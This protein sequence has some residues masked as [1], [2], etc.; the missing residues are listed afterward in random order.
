MHLARVQRWLRLA[1]PEPREY[2]HRLR[3]MLPAFALD[4][5]QSM[6]DDERADMED[7]GP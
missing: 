1:S 4:L 2:T 6:E 5:V 3:I 7:P